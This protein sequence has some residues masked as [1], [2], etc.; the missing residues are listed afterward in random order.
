MLSLIGSKSTRREFLSIG[1]LALGGL[2]LGS[3]LRTKG[4]AAPTTEL[5][6][7]KSVVFVFMHGGPAQ[8]ETFDPKMTAPA[9][10]RSTT[11]E[12]KTVLPGVTFGGSFEK[13]AAR[14]DRLA[15]VRSFVPGDAQHNI[16]P[17]VCRE[18][19]DANIG[20]I[21]SRIVGQNN[22]D[23]GLPTNCLLYPRAVDDSTMPA[24]LQFGRFDS[25]GQLGAAYA[26]FAPSSGG[27]MQEDMKLKIP[28]DRLDDRRSLLAQL[29]QV[30]R[31][32]DESKVGDTG[33]TLSGNAIEQLR[34]QAF[35]TILGGA[36]EAFD[37]DKEDAKTVAAYDTSL[38]VQP[39][40]IS[41]KWANYR[42]YIDNAKTLG[43]L[44]L[45]ARRLCERGVGFVTITT[46]FVWDMHA[47][48]N[49]ATMV[50]GMRYM[51]P[52]FDHAISAFLDDVAARG[53]SDDILLVCCGE[54]GRAPKLNQRGGRDHW[55][56]LGPLLLAGGGIEVGQV[57]GQS[58]SDVA[59]P[60]TTPVTNE[61]LIGTI[62]QTMFRVG[63]VRLA[64]NLP[65]G[66]TNRLAGYAPIP[67]L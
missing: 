4:L 50:E 52:P 3:L 54:M 5:A 9:G 23:S 13:L 65:T 18:S 10:I 55:G 27:T 17:I 44:L 43:K 34:R 42:R 48:A 22:P 56:G 19:L 66:I 63:A 67:G 38:L 24:I 14:A 58:T 2:S 41:T 32:L 1:S 40:Q 28:L 30:K 29:D 53:L 60:Q 49:N 61:H 46:N 57:I 26:P 59:R 25:T 31:T 11:G 62:L 15:I 21:Y 51:A 12:V 8:T 39:S 20:S 45:L 16:K 35:D 33:N 7:G 6:T 37:L 36:A 47:D 64:D